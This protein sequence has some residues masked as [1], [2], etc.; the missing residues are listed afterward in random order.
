MLNN[1]PV[2]I[3]SLENESILNATK[4]VL[5][6]LFYENNYMQYIMYA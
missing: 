2:F 4:H 1:Y 3:T 6:N 5:L